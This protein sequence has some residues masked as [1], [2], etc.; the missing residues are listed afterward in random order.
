[1]VTTQAFRL[2]AEVYQ[3]SRNARIKPFKTFSVSTIFA[4]SKGESQKPCGHP[5]NQYCYLIRQLKRP[6]F[7]VIAHDFSL[8]AFRL[9]PSVFNLNTYSVLSF[10]IM[11][12]IIRDQA[13]LTDPMPVK[14]YQNLRYFDND[15]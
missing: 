8:K 12:K 6:K 13:I 9:P 5:I 2:K 10:R 7:C 3:S 15:L 1:M 4:S 14:L 11:L